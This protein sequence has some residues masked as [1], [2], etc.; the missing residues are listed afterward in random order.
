MS[1]EPGYDTSNLRALQEEVRRLNEAALESGLFSTPASAGVGRRRATGDGA[2]GTSQNPPRKKAERNRGKGA[3]RRLR[4][5]A[6]RTE[7]DDS[8]EV[9][10]TTFTEAG[11]VR[12]LSQ[13]RRRRKRPGPWTRFLVRMERAL[14][15][16]VPLGQHTIAG[17]SLARLQVV[18]SQLEQIEARGLAY[19]EARRAARRG[20]LSQTGTLMLGGRPPVAES[21]SPTRRPDD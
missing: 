3:A 5:V 19:L 8:P 14:S 11:V 7:G 15:R 17:I 1:A 4:S 2:P 9:P 16:P 10:G 12:L 13:L 20:R 6:G 18:S 21:G